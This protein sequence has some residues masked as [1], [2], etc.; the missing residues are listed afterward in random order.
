MVTTPPEFRPICRAAKICCLSFFAL[1]FCACSEK[2]KNPRRDSSFELVELAEG[3]EASG[4]ALSPAAAPQNSAQNAAEPFL[5]PPQASALERFPQNLESLKAPQTQGE[6]Q[7]PQIPQNSDSSFIKKSEKGF[8]DSSLGYHAYL[9]YYRSKSFVAPSAPL[10][11]ASGG[12]I[13]WPA[14]IK[15]F[16]EG[17]SFEAFIQPTLGKTPSSG[18]FGDVRNNGYRFHEGIDIKPA[19][20]DKKSEPLD[21]VRAAMR[22]RVALINKVAGNSSYGRYVVLAHENLDVPVYTLYAH[23]RSIDPLLSPSK[24]VEAGEKIGVMGRS[25]SYSIA[26]ECAH[27]HFEVGLMY[28]KHFQKWYDSKRYTS[29]NFFGNYNGMNL[30][31]MDPLDFFYTAKSGG[32]NAGLADFIK[33]Q[34]TAFVVRYYTQKTPDFANMYPA[35]VDPIGQ[36]CGWD[37]YFT[38]WGLPHK[39]SRI[40]NPSARAKDGHIEIAEFD[41]QCVRHRCANFVKTDSSGRARPTENLKDI[42]KKMF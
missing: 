29:K 39:I 36:K 40:K 42:L 33:N 16:D 23:L 11:A 3:G 21:D 19:R 37:I 12:K 10:S 15:A 14:E 41:G 5:N 9:P 1:L 24:I 25:A 34:K 38:W 7:S 28:G 6:I 27:L 35:L 4:A 2:M 8:C 13:L 26:K 22:G 30:C 32:L 31:G 20:R 18:L 17:E